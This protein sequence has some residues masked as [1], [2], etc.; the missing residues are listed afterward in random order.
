MAQN[1]TSR[2]IPPRRLALEACKADD[3]S[4]MAQAI[5]LA[6]SPESRDTVQEVIRASLRR[7]VA[8]SATRVLS[9]L[10]DDQ[11][12]DVSAISGGTIASVSSEESVEP[13]R[14]VLEILLAH[15]WDIDSRDRNIGWPL[16]WYA[17]RYPDLLAWCLAHGASVY[18]PGDT[19]PRDA[20]GIGQVPRISL[21]EYVAEAGTVAT[22]E[23]LRARGAPFHRRT[24]H[25]AVEYAA[26]YAP[27]YDSA[28]TSRFEERMDMVRHLVDTLGLDVN[29]EDG[30]PGKPYATPLY[31]VASYNNGKDASELIWFLL[32]HGADPNYVYTFR[33]EK[34]SSVLEQ[35]EANRYTRFLEAVQEW[36]TRKHQ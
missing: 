36:Q 9:Y 8:S 27:P 3:V 26:I 35:A 22:F 5:L 32:D 31:Y 14:E 4:L 25:R 1:N 13:S 10:L 34:V 12:A 20:N 2:P 28:R 7:S 23:L 30:W 33:G 6:S 16:L 24:L 18:L 11:G 15:G 19:P 29:A 21:L 17:V